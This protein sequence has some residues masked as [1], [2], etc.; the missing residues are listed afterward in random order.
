MKYI[1]QAVGISAVVFFFLS[2]QQKERKKIIVL[3][4]I[5]RILYVVQYLLLGA[6]EGCVLD[7]VGML[8]SVL[9]QKKD[10]ALIRKHP[11]AW[12][13]GMQILI[14]ACGLALYRN[15]FSLLPIVGVM[16]HTGA[17]WITDE[18]TSRR[19][20]ILGS[21]FRLVY[22]LVSH[23]YGSAIGDV[24]S[25]ISIGVAIYRYDIR[26]KGKKEEKTDPQ[27]PAS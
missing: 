7:V 12:M 3:N 6:Y 18:K 9:A 20:S 2:Y 23:A 21:P 25:M 26:K 13:I 11:K 5:S 27:P 8:S 4:V 14:A 22:N 19:L 24:S 17:F 16:L 15:V 10:S 1:A